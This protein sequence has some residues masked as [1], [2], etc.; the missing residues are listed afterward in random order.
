MKMELVF[1][2]L[3]NS[4]GLTFPAAFLRAHGVR[5]GQ[6]VVVEA[7]D[8]GTITLQPKAIRKRYTAAQLNAQCDLKAAMP[9][10]LVAWERAPAVGSEAP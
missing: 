5:E 4:T 8:D 9:S 7:A 2:R 3:G 1:K 10:D 6:T